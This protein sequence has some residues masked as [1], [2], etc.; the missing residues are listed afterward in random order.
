MRKMILTK[1]LDLVVFEKMH[2]ISKSESS[3][4]RSKSRL[5]PDIDWDEEIDNY[6][7]D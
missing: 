3:D 6:Q 2:D 5:Y 7:M 4:I 1:F